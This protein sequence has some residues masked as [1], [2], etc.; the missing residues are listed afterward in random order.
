[1]KQ[2]H[3]QCSIASHGNAANSARFAARGNA[4]AAFD[5]GHELPQEK[6]LIAQSVV[7]RV[8]EETCVTR[9]RDDD[10]IAKLAPVPK[11]LDQIEAA[12]AHEHLLVVAESVE[13][14]DH[15]IAAVGVIAPTQS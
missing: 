15:R 12:G 10:E 14:I 1:M 6:I 9:R 13:V 2:R 7:V 3:S 4:V 5:C 11:L 8:H